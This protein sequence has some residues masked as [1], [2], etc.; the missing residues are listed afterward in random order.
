M[1]MSGSSKRLKSYLESILP[2]GAVEELAD[3]QETVMRMGGAQAGRGRKSDGQKAHAAM[4]KLAMGQDVTAEEAFLVEAII[5]PDKRPAV[6]I[7]D[8][9]FT[10]AQA[11]WAHYSEDADLKANILAAIPAVGRVELPDHSSLPYG[12]TGFLVADNLIMTNRHVAAIF[13]SGLG[14]EG[15]RFIPGQTAAVDFKRERDS[16]ASQF[17]RVANI[18]MIHPYWD[19]ALLEVEGL[20]AGIE[21]LTLSMREP[22]DL[23]GREIALVGYPAFDPRNDAKV[24]NQ[25]FGGVYNVKRLLPGLLKNRRAIRSYGFS[26]RSV[27]HDASSLGGASGSGV[28]DVASGEVVALHFAGIYKDANFA[29]PTYELSRDDH[30]VGAGVAFGED[31]TSN[32]EDPNPWAVQWADADRGGEAAGAAVATGQAATAGQVAATAAPGDGVC[33]WTVPLIVDIRMG[34]PQPAGQALAAAG[35]A[36]AAAEVERM[37]EPTHDDDYTDRPGYDPAFVGVDVPM[38]TATSLDRVSKLDDDTHVLDY[39]HFS[40]IVDKHRRLPLITAANVDT[41]PD[42][43]RP[44]PGR[45]YGRRALNG[46]TSKN[47]REKWFPDPRIP[48]QHQL[49]DKFF[50]KDRKAFDKGHV[51]RR[52]AVV[53]GSTYEEVQLA[54]GDT[55]H[56]TN[57][58]PQVKGF[59]RSTEGGIW[60][61]LENHVFKQAK[62]RKLCIFAGPVLKD[63][64]PFFSGFD[65]D[66]AIRV[67][68]PVAYWKIAVAQHG[69]ALQV[70]AFKLEQDLSDVAFEFQVTPKWKERMVRL[71]ALE[72]ELEHVS[73]DSSLHDADQAET[74]AGE[75]VRM[76]AGLKP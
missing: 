75:A 28:L 30:V 29:V 62:T 48:A 23:A 70:F 69:G 12:G 38:P 24:Q 27:T 59:N 20:P 50:N 66:G 43:L 52:N 8:G 21:P 7:L 41:H 37:V 58:T 36:P 18:E 51:V 46:F 33:R 16:S 26:V 53:W 42:S 11:D 71:E 44:E 47:D 25:V 67:R 60:G 61:Q 55:F 35:V 19:M 76:T 22:E 32:I 6:D 45:N 3:A 40:L 13:A 54:N 49:P 10:V 31:G 4:Q 73:F 1:S 74:G 34:A 14:R 64:D 63:S 65:D 39:Y 57:C 9:D 56:S 15:L 72:S 17:V 2:S 68:I 5:I